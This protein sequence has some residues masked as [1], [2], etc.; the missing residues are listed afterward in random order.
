MQ[1][2]VNLIIP[3]FWLLNGVE[4]DIVGIKGCTQELVF[5][6]SEAD[7]DDELELPLNTLN[8]FP[9]F[10]I[11]TWLTDTHLYIMKNEIIQKLLPSSSQ[12]DDA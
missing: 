2:C 7:L 6:A 10:K 12:P 3:M 4:R 8:K 5:M 1:A 11:F 9:H